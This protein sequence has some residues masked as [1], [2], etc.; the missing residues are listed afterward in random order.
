MKHIKMLGLAVVAMAAF[1][2]FASSASATPALTSPAGT[3]Y[4]GEL[5]ATMKTGTSGLLQAGFANIT[6]T[7]STVAGKVEKNVTNTASGKIA[8][9]TFAKCNA[10]V[11]VLKLGSLHIATKDDGTNSGT[12]SGSGSEVTVST[13][14]TSC[15]YGTG[16]ETLLG[17]AKGSA[18]PTSAAE[19]SLSGTL[20]KISGGFAC[21]NPAKWTASYVLTKP[22]PLFID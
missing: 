4:T 12:V 18:S 3:E 16:T 9:L 11:D 5:H 10:T 8:T 17:T 14:G 1:M 20:P 6:C 13:L 22:V 19:M 15:V 7:E 2:A 21:A